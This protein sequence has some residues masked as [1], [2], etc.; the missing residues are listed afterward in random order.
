MVSSPVSAGCLAAFGCFSFERHLSFGSSC[1]SCHPS[2]SLVECRP[3]DLNFIMP[4]QVDCSSSLVAFF[5]PTIYQSVGSSS[6]LPE[7][8]QSLNKDSLSTV[9]FLRNGAVRVTFKSSLDC[10]RVVSSG[11]RF[12]DVPLRVMSADT[13]SRLVY[14][15][16]CPAE[17]PDN[18][19][20]RFFSS[21]GEVHSVSRSC[22]QTFPGLFDGNRVVKV[23]LTKDVPGIVS[24]NGHQCR[25][26]YR[27][28][29]AFCAICRK[30]G[31]RS[32]SCPLNGLCRRCRRPS[33]HARE[34]TNAWIPAAGTAPET[35]GSAANPP[36][37][38]SAS[39]AAPAD[40]VVPPHRP[41]SVDVTT[42]VADPP[43]PADASA[44]DETEMLDGEYV[45]STDDDSKRRRRTVSSAVPSVLVGMD[46][47][48]V[49]VPGHKQFKTFRGVWEDV[50]SWEE[51]R[52]RKSRYRVVVTPHEPSS[53]PSL[54]PSQS[55]SA[56]SPT[57]VPP[58][59]PVP[60]TFSSNGSV[61][62]SVPTPTPERP[63]ASSYAFNKPR[64]W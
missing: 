54:F 41:A 9:Q 47:S 3:S 43:V 64:L 19:V 39:A 8:L 35:R 29:P 6:V 14:L 28:Q 62:D 13:R 59:S 52:S 10:A 61:V 33:H 42:P 2:S 21:F 36:G 51:L 44:V 23:T 37:S 34:C 56:S 17:V 20:K 15:R 58:A 1:R 26:W 31:H 63:R 4:A 32:K 16:N 7:L 45:P 12:R 27:R 49:E 55:I 46:T 40:P 5:P 24:V 25:V 53:T 18:V 48:D 50:V 57:P 22:H 30:L 38:A 11:I 60:S